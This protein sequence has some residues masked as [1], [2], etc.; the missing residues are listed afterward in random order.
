MLT[1]FVAA[2]VY[3]V[4]Q[5]RRG[6]RIYGV[7]LTAATIYGLVLA[8]LRAAKP[9]RRIEPFTAA[10][11][12]TY[13]ASFAEMVIANVVFERGITQYIVVQIV[14]LILMTAVALFPVLTRRQEGQPAVDQLAS[15]TGA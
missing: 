15:S 7:V 9:T 13:V 11:I 12:F 2:A 1:M 3:S 6:H 14:G 10:I 5:F 8:A 4:V